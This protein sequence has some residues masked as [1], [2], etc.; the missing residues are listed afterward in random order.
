[1]TGNT[2]QLT[3]DVVQFFL[4]KFASTQTEVTQMEASESLERIS[5]FVPTIAGFAL[6]GLLAACFV[7]VSESWWS[8]SLPLIIISIL[9]I[10]AYVEHARK[11]IT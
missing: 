11:P 5:R 9:A 6:G 2:T 4:S 8:L 3:I 7:L 10:A 1:M